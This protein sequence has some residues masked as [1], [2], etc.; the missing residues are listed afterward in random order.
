[1]R[2]ARFSQGSSIYYGALE[3]ESTRIVGLKGDPLF[4]PVE[5][6]GQIFELDEVR[7]LSP[8]I[9]RSKVIGLGGNYPAPGA[10]PSDPRERRLPIRSPMPSRNASSGCRP[11][12][13]KTT[14]TYRPTRT[15][16]KHTVE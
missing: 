14:K 4:S 16:R 3:D 8:V 5:P 9:P 12:P 2:I 15:E 10:A 6:S 7:L 1:M 13:R 11:R